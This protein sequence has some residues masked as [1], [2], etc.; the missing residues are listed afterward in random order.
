MLTGEILARAAAR[1]PDRGAIIA[2][3]RRLDYR[4]LDR[5]ASRFAH[6]L[7]GRGSRPGERVAM[8]CGNRPEYAI[9]Y[10]GIAR[11]GGVSAHLSPRYTDD[12][13]AHALALV[14]ARLAV[15]EAP[16]ADRVRAIRHRAPTLR[17]VIVVDDSGFGEFLDAMPEHDPGLALDPSDPASI[18]FTGGT[19]ACP[20][21]RC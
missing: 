9:A 2:G 20:G 3:A 17:H 19:T 14:E 21:A 13:I 12:E 6:A 16:L 11:A 8:L 10:F 15:V 7:I 1:F 5:Q 4:T 18:T